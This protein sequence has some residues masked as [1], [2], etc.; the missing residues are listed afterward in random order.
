MRY[1]GLSNTPKSATV[2]VHQSWLNAHQSRL[3]PSGCKHMSSKSRF[4]HVTVTAVPS[5][6]YLHSISPL[7]CVHLAKR[8]LLLDMLGP[9]GIRDVDAVPV[10]GSPGAAAAN[11]LAFKPKRSIL[12]RGQS[13]ST[14]KG[15]CDKCGLTYYWPQPAREPE[16]WYLVR[17]ALNEE[18]AIYDGTAVT[19]VLREDVFD[20][21]KRLDVKEIRLRELPILDEPLDGLPANLPTYL[22]P[23]RQ[24]EFGD[25]L[26]RDVTEYDRRWAER[27]GNAEE[28]KRTR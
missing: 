1:Y 14:L 4:E 24:K 19:L 5:S 13:T 11:C 18:R 6:V 10:M 7:E 26:T 3:F 12:V 22:T 9:N 8:D 23:E 27:M 21:V 17:E 16:K 2:H 28:V 20:R 25:L 15:A